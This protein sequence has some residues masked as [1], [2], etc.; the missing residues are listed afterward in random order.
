MQRVV[1]ILAILATTL[2]A[3]HVRSGEPP[4]DFTNSIGMKFKLIP[5]GEFMMGHSE[6]GQVAHRES[7]FQNPR[8]PGRVSSAQGANIEVLLPGRN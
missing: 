7:K 6:S 3:G 8:V 5:A 2:I 1:R 4:K